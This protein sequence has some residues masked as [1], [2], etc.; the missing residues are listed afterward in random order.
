[1]CFS[2]FAIE[3]KA[4]THILRIINEEK[5]R[6]ESGEWGEWVAK[7][8]REPF[9]LAGRELDWI[10]FYHACTK[11]QTLTHTKCLFVAHGT[12]AWR[13]ERMLD[14]SNILFFFL[15]FVS[16]LNMRAEYKEKQKAATL[17]IAI[18]T[19]PTQYEIY[20]FVVVVVAT[21]SFCSLSSLS[22][23]F[24]LR[25]YINLDNL[26]LC[27]KYIVSAPNAI[28]VKIKIDARNCSKCMSVFVRWLRFVKFF[29]LRYWKLLLCFDAGKSQIKELLMA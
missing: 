25:A 2:F 16:C 12:V 24:C 22:F 8:N 1:M 13:N 28:K 9:E 11:T 7:K 5:K 20:L 29:H 3:T 19:T 4:P 10:Q 21:F 26:F 18:V 15:Y 27:T 23:G 6:K 14:P 17:F